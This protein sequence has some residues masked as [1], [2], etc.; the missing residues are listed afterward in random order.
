VSVASEPGMVTG[1][2][3]VVAALERAGVELAFGLPGVH[4]LAL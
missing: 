3:L 4:N 1:A 2:R